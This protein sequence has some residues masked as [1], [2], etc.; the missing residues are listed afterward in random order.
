M[1]NRAEKKRVDP[2]V[3]IN[4]LLAELQIKPT[5]REWEQKNDYVDTLLTQLGASHR[6]RSLELKKQLEGTTIS[7]FAGT[8]SEN[9]KVELKRNKQFLS[10]IKED[11]VNDIK[12]MSELPLEDVNLR[13]KAHEKC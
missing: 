13:H 8:Q 7:K 2:K 6:K 12:A 9:K 3:K 1:N 11:Y 4:E 10:Q 5:L